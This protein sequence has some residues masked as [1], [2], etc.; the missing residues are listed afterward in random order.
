M[1]NSYTDRI[2]ARINKQTDKG[3]KK[4]GANLQEN[5]INLSIVEVVEYALE[6]VTDALIYLENVKERLAQKEC[7]PVDD[8]NCRI[9]AYQVTTK[10]ER[11]KLGRDPCSACRDNSNWRP[12]EN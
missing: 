10:E 7:K 11:D 5:P 1:K 9:C 12:K 8:I 3:I 4:Y 2:I 6:E